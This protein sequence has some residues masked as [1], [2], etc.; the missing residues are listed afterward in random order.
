MKRHPT[1]LVALLFGL[2]VV[3]LGAAFLVHENTGRGVDAAWASAIGFVV[4][5]LVALGV[6]LLGR[7][8]AGAAPADEERA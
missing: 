3:G 1:D 4:L 7:R 8:Q 2:A 5:G 6:T